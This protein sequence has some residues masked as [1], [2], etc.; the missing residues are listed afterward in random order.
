MARLDDPLFHVVLVAPEIPANTGN[1]GRT[2]LGTGCRLHL[3]EPLGF[4]MD[5]RALKRAGL[6]YWAQVDW[7][8]HATWSDL[9]ATVPDPSR[10]FLF[11]TRVA[12]PYTD[13]RFR[14]G[15]WLVFGRET[16]GLP[17]ALLEAWPSQCLTLP[18]PGAI[19]SL[20]LAVAAGVA[21]F[22]GLRQV[23][24]AAPD[25]RAA[26]GPAHNSAALRDT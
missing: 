4:S 6:D 15:D 12:R 14:R 1:I 24:G 9:L 18:M 3:V 19:R 20:N 16:A 2:C 23:Q 13:Q 8:L 21:V 25:K 22:E 7:C 11:S 10:L 17:A 5:D 26:T